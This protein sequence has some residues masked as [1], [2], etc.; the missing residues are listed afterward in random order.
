[1][2]RIPTGRV[3]EPVYEE[4]EAAEPSG[5]EDEFAPPGRGDPEFLVPDGEGSPAAEAADMDQE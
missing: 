4:S 3:Y 1:M 2:K 5:E